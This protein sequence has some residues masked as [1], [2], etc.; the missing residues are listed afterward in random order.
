MWQPEL[1]PFP[2]SFVESL[3]DSMGDVVYCVKDRQGR[4]QSVNQAFVERVGANDKHAVV[5][6]T[7]YDFFPPDLA[8]LFDAQD[9][10]VFSKGLA[11]QD[12]LERISHRGGG[13]G[14]FL[15]SK[16]PITGPTGVT[17]ALVGISQD[18]HS[19]SDSELELSNL[20]SVVD[21][22]RAN[23]DQ[24]LRVEQLAQSIGL[25]AAQLDRRMKPIFR[26]STKKFVIKCRLEEAAYRLAYT[27]QPLSAIALAC[28][29]SDQSAF[30]R[31]FRSTAGMP[32]LSYRK[33][34]RF[35]ENH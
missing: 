6:S 31:Q 11:I 32:P 17:V 27:D 18:L 12:Q 13:M 33:R 34:N 30:S 4:Y 14:W 7:A 24:P 21:H 23:L 29:F 15:A 3:F 16:F 2:G 20:K 22:I 10:A 5:G 35:R 26:L 9:Q 8:T 19:P 1:H 28:G 25:T